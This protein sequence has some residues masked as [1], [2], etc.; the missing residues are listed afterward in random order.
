MNT[1]PRRN[2]HYR[3]AVRLA[4]RLCGYSRRDARM[5]VDQFARRC[6]PHAL[7]ALGIVFEERHRKIIR[8][9][10]P[11]ERVE[12][13]ATTLALMQKDERTGI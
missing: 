6:N 4:R 12:I 10:T 7:D 13:V 9:F 1:S 3:K 8:L 11:N 5:Y 2:R